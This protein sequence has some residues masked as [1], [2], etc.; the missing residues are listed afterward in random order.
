MNS[1]ASAARVPTPAVVGQETRIA[2]TGRFYTDS[3]EPSR[4]SAARQG[5]SCTSTLATGPRTQTAGNSWRTVFPW[6]EGNALFDGPAKRRDAWI[7]VRDF[8]PG[9]PDEIRNQRARSEAL[10]L[11]GLRKRWLP[12]A[13]K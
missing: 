11:S 9:W 6:D 4:G 12:Q 7:I 10:L 5:C 13:L 8:W 2:G 3:L 1:T